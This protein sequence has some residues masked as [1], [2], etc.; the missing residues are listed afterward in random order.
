MPEP[1]IESIPPTLFVLPNGTEMTF[2]LHRCPDF[3]TLLPLVVAGGGVLE[4]RVRTN[5]IL[6]TEA[7]SLVES[8]RYIH[9]QYVRDC[10][11]ARRRLP[12][13]GYKV[14]PGIPVPEIPSRVPHPAAS[15]PYSPNR[16][17]RK[18]FTKVESESVQNYIS[19]HGLQDK[20][21]GHSIWRSMEQLGVTSHSAE[22]MRAHYL[23]L[24]ARDKKSKRLTKG[25]RAKPVPFTVEEDAAILDYVKR[26]NLFDSKFVNQRKIWEEMNRCLGMRHSAESMRSRF[27]RRLLEKLSSSEDDKLD[28]ISISETSD[29]ASRTENM[30]S[31][32][33]AITSSPL[34]RTS[35]R[36]SQ[37]IA[38]NRHSRMPRGITPSRLFPVSPVHTER[39]LSPMDT[40]PLAEL[41]GPVAAPIFSMFH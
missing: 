22:G 16:R 34:R 17:T 12:M 15:V 20:V 4:K 18:P 31:T 41:T 25:S 24:L 37:R 8:D 27:R 2:T 39:D 6:L 32:S 9:V 33:T 11:R 40:S 23:H 36:F 1:S 13:D 14:I 38:R 7:G 28:D 26:N 30:A 10:I 29:I 19:K 21:H 35:I 5:S 3:F